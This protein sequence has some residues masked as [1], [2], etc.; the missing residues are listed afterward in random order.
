MQLYLLTWFKYFL[1]FALSAGK[2]FCTSMY[3]PKFY[4]I[5]C[6]RAH[7]PLCHPARSV[8]LH[9]VHGAPLQGVQFRQ[10]FYILRTIATTTT[11]CALKWGE[12]REN[13]E[14]FMTSTKYSSKI[15]FLKDGIYVAL[16]TFCLKMILTVRFLRLQRW[17][18]PAFFLLD[19]FVLRS[20]HIH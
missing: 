10:F 1:R 2:Y 12:I 14:Y 19:L 20:R 8:L 16:S 9:L 4:S 3:F 18:N 15:F 7:S 5:F 13:S 11:I 17:W 6:A